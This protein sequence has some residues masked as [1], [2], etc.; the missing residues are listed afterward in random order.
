VRDIDATRPSGFASG[1][2]SSKGKAAAGR[3]SVHLPLTEWSIGVAVSPQEVTAEPQVNLVLE[4]GFLKMRDARGSTQF[5]LEIKKSSID[6]VKYV[7]IKVST[8]P[9]VWHDQPLRRLPE[10]YDLSTT[11]PAS[12]IRNG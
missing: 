8:P 11:N 5:E 4:S 7:D 6:E 9:S 1:S 3:V 2:K 12:P 10:N